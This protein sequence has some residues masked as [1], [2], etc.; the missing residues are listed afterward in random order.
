MLRA[1][2]VYVFALLMVRL[3]GDRRFAGKHAAFDVLLAVILGSTFSR[4]ITG[5]V[6]FFPALAAAAVLVGLHWFFAAIAFR[7]HRFEGLI[8]G[9]A[10]VLIRDGQICPRALQRNKITRKELESALLQANA[11]DPSQVK[12]ARLETSGTISVL[13]HQ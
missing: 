10:E 7:S 1:A 3:G 6:P 2:V 11:T 12:L 4:A 5:T 13:T 8:K 9:E